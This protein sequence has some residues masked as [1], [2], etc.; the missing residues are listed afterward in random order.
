MGSRFSN[1]SLSTPT[2]A[3]ED[4]PANWSAKRPTGRSGTGSKPWKSMRST[5]T[6]ATIS[7]G[8]TS[9]RHPPTRPA[10]WCCRARQGRRSRPKAGVCRYLKRAGRSA[11]PPV[12]TQVG[13]GFRRRADC[14]PR[15]L[16]LAIRPTTMR[17]PAESIGNYR[18]RRPTSEAQRIH[19]N[20]LSR[21]RAAQIQALC[22][23]AN[24]KFCSQQ[25][26]PDT[27]LEQC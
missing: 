12:T 27:G 7:S 5:A 15:C 14:S 8:N 11:K 25:L 9:L 21:P 2:S 16:D 18:R 6:R 17:C 1:R 10:R 3:V 4:R 19:R 23:P 22:V 24:R 13:C 20:R 26:K